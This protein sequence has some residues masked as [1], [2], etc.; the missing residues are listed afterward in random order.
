MAIFFRKFAHFMVFLLFFQLDSVSVAGLIRDTEVETIFQDAVQRMAEEAGF[1]DGIKIRVIV[2]PS[3]NAFVIGGQTVYIHTGLLLSA[4][5][6]E[7]I[8]GVIAHEIGHLAAGHA[9]LRQEAV[10]DANLAT[11]LTA[12]ASA[13]VAAT[14][15][16]EAAVGVAIGGTDSAKRQYLSTSRKDES[17]ADEWALRLLDKAGISSF[18][19]TDFMRRQASERMLTQGRQSEYYTTHP[20]AKERLATFIE[21]T[22]QIPKDRALSRTEHQLLAR[23]VLK[24]AA[25]IHSHRLPQNMQNSSWTGLAHHPTQPKLYL[26]RQ[27]S[28]TPELLPYSGVALWMQQID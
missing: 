23:A 24:L 19:L 13:A 17:V 22:A 11:A 15:S 16:A 27:A 2:D 1:A 7:E 14:G 28:P 4:R 6:A 20:G 3:Y 8:L 25:F 9:P 26:M 18:G 21:H 10:R 5:S 12:I